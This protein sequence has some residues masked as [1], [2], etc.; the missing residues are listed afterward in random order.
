M[1][2]PM[3]L[4][5]AAVWLAL[6]SEG[7]PGHARAVRYWEEEAHALVAFC[8]VTQLRLLQDLTDP[9]VMRR[10]VLQPAAAYAKYQEL[11]G[12]P[13][14]GYLEEPPGLEECWGSYTAV[15]P[16]ASQLSVAVYL[17]AF[18][19]VAH[20]RLVTFDAENGEFDGVDKL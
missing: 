10:A 18:A 13:E 14:V 2:E 11:L 1:A 7:Q 5:D 16:P 3:D 15:L 6:V 9:K 8:R 19:R 20:A 4:L 12:L 17:A